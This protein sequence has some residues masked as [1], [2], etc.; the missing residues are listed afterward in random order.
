[1]EGDAENLT[2]MLIDL[3]SKHYIFFSKI[4][5][6]RLEMSIAL[7]FSKHTQNVVTI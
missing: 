4:C 7:Q 1:M 5:T 6:M 3:L 2:L